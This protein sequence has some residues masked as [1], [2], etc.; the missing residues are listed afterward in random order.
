MTV[1]HL[2]FARK[3]VNEV[4]RLGE[5]KL[6]AMRDLYA[7]RQ[8]FPSVDAF[9]QAK[10][11]LETDPRFFGGDVPRLEGADIA[12]LADGKDK[13][14]VAVSKFLDQHG[15]YLDDGATV[16]IEGSFGTLTAGE[17]RKETQRGH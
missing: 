11:A 7:R 1:K 3:L 4:H 14:V 5:A 6:T 17:L 8:E 15:E 13:D 9:E 2:K 16:F 12:G 10:R